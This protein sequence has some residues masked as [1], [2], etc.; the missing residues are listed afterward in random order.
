M[1]LHFFGA[2]HEVT[3]SCHMI[4]STQGNFLLDCGMFQGSDF[5]EAKNHDEFPFDIK[6]IKALFVSHAHL[7]HVGRIPKLVKDGYTGPIYM[8]KAT[9]ELAK[10]IWDDAYHIMKY[11]NEKFQSPILFD[12]EDITAAQELCHGVEYDT[13]LK[14]EG[15]EVIFYDAGHIFGSAFVE[16]RAE[17]KSIVFSGDVGNENAPIVRDTENLPEMD[18]MLCE[19]TYGDK[20]HESIEDRDAMLLEVIKEGVKRGG[21]IMIPA[22]SLERTQELLYKLH[23]MSEHDKTLPNV[24]IFLDSPLAIDAIE[25]YRKYKGYYDAAAAEEYREGDDF[26]SFPTLRVTRTRDD[27]KAI[28]NVHGAKIVIAGSGMMNGGRIVHHAARYVGDPKS[29]LVIIGY[30]AQGTLGRRLYEGAEKVKILGT[31]I[32]VKCTVKAIGAFSAHADQV[33]L[34]GWIENC[35]MK[36]KKLY[37][38]H[39]EPEAATVLAHK[40]RDQFGI[41]T[42]VPE[43]GESVEV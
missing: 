4:E 41:A 11:E 1:K 28:N 37:C 30:Q 33:K 39:G 38:V 18:I 14:V 36:P 19:S 12:Q 21:T 24:P 16:V 34:L 5:N 13:W 17:G 15:V 7:D 26:L 3:G 8:T 42:F 9:V 27:S 25:V 22:F 35:K 29:T 23:L 2:A 43:F 20:I 10:L 6:S 32:D 31:E 40:I